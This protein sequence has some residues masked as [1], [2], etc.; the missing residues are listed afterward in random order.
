MAP[1]YLLQ[2]RLQTCLQ[3]AGGRLALMASRRPGVAGSFLATFGELREAGVSEQDAGRLLHD[4]IEEPAATTL[5]VYQR[6]LSS[7]ADLE[8]RGRVD[9]AG[10]VQWAVQ[11][12]A[13]WSERLAAVYLYGA[14]ELIGVHIDLLRA[15]AVGTHVTVLLP[16]D[17]ERPAW[18]YGA[19]FGNQ[20]LLAAGD[21]LE[22]L[23]APGAGAPARAAHFLYDEGA[24]PRPAPLDDVSFELFHT[25]G[26]EAELTAVARRILELHGRGVPL[27]EI[28]VVG[29]ILDPYAPHLAVVFARHGIPFS[30]SA[31]Q[32][33]RRFPA[34]RALLTLLR[35]LARNF[36]RGDL[37]ALLRSPLFICPPGTRQRPD[38]LERWSA[39]AGIHKGL[40]AWTQDLPAWELQRLREIAE[41]MFEDPAERDAYRRER[42][43]SFAEQMTILQ[44]LGREAAAWVQRVGWAEQVDFVADVAGR[45]LRGFE[46][47]APA[48]PA[49][50]SVRLKIEELR[51]AGD[52][53]AEGSVEPG[54]LLGALEG[55]IAAEE[56]PVAEEDKDG[57]LVLDGMQARGHAFR[58]VFLVGFNAGSFPRLL[59]EDPFLPDAVRASLR[60]ELARPVPL[61]HNLEEEHLLLALWISSASDRVVVSYRRADEDGRA[62]V[63]SF[64][65]RELARLRVG[66]P[67]TAALAEGA[68]KV[69]VHPVDRILHWQAYP[70]LV[71]PAEASLLVALGEGNR[72]A[73]VRAGLTTSGGRDA[74]LEAALQWMNE[75]GGGWSSGEGKAGPVP[76]SLLPLAWSPS[77]LQE[78]GRCPLRFFFEHILGIEPSDE[79]PMEGVFDA[80]DWGGRVHALL[81]EL[82]RTLGR[83]PHLD[84]D[85]G[86]LRP[87][88]ETRC[89]DLVDGLWVEH[90][91]DLD[92][93]VSRRLPLLWEEHARRWRESLAAFVIRDVREW[94]TR[95]LALVELEYPGALTLAGRGSEPP[96]ALRGRVDRVAR[97]SDELLVVDYKTG[98]TLK[99]LGEGRAALS[100]QQLQ[101]SLYAW[102]EEARPDAPPGAKVS[103]EFLGVGPHYEQDPESAHLRVEGADLRAWRA[104]VEETVR[105]LVGLASAG[106]FPFR[107]DPEQCGRCDFESACHH[108]ERDARRAVEASPEHADYFDVHHKT[109][110]ADTLA[111]VRAARGKP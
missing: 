102:M 29:R 98:R 19:R 61:R 56:L 38:W 108:R 53:D 37:L 36:E 90:F 2:R 17:H 16:I 22:P 111:K 42:E 54:A 43:A 51:A 73:A 100:G 82:Y 93:R 8:R 81:L 4:G 76:A 46:P 88:E 57:V 49:V 25:Q 96:L 45:W 9:R 86:P 47:G 83:G 6:Y 104:G 79:L 26:A 1:E 91:G 62:E 65:L 12:A 28:G 105:T 84:A 14:Y 59:G 66:R 50:D 39:Q 71:T 3:A 44:A 31:T 34:P 97:C 64:A 13:A 33:L 63:P 30:T 78:V 7:L 72:A 69:P 40:P 52:A 55:L 75:R 77:R 58:V 110:K 27:H 21:S 94:R 107:H 68:R 87:E 67:R 95:G 101:A 10:L 80:A 70:G 85:A 41:R 48:D 5:R 11:R 60:Q 18:I 109:L 15:L 89:R 23:D 106:R 35:T 92:E 24:A 20:F 99:H 74:A 32:P 103:V